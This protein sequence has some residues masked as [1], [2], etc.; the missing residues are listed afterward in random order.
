MAQLSVK[1][2]HQQVER[3]EAR[4][5]SDKK[6]IL[7]NA[8]EISGRTLTDFVIHAA[9]EAAMRVIQEHQQIHL[10]SSDK[11]VFIQTLLNPPDLSPNLV[12]ASTRYKKDVRSQ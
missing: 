8:A 11:E 4:I 7:R 2:P 1:Q 9:Y 12:K 3:L 5:S 10:V 6:N